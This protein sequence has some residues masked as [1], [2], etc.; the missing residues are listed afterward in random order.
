MFYFDFSGTLARWPEFVHA[1][2]YTILLS[3]AAMLLGLV[4]GIVGAFARLSSIKPARLIAGSYVEIIRN[5]PF[6]VQ[7]Y[8]V[9]FGLPAIGI[10]LD[11]LTAGILSLSLYAGAYITEIARAGIETID[12]GQVEAARALGLSPYL[13]FRHVILK[14]AMAAVYPALTSQFIL[15]MLATSVVSVISIPEL[16]GVA[17]D[18][19]GLTFRS[20]EAFLIVAVIYLGLTAAFKGLFT[21]FDRTLFAFKYVGR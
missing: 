2:L 7:I 21:V 15:V 8:I 10:R 12:K 11:A 3:A 18:I 1:G 13:T 17:N 4:I 16:T 9:Y 19:Q 5:T 20:L 6:L 14:P